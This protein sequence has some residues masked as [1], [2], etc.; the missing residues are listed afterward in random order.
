MKEYPQDRPALEL[1]Q[2]TLGMV[3][4]LGKV[5]SFLCAEAG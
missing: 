3:C 5:I 4:A 1:E 2:K